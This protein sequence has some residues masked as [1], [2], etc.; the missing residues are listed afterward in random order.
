[1]FGGRLVY[2]LGDATLVLVG[3]GLDTEPGSLLG[4]I[5][6]IGIVNKGATPLLTLY[7]SIPGVAEGVD[8]HVAVDLEGGVD[9]AVDAD[10]LAFHVEERAARIAAEH[11][12]VRADDLFGAF[13]HAP[14][15]HGGRASGLESA[16][17]PHGQNP[18]TFFQF[19][20]FTHVDEEPFV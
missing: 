5:G 2:N 3:V 18:L 17:M 4:V 13:E 1:L 6:D 15:S 20:R 8:R 19:G 11:G 9:A 10:D 16:G 14:E 12:A 7:Q